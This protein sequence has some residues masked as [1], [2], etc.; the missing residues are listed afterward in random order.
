[1]SLRAVLGLA[2]LAASFARL[3]GL[4]AYGFSEDE[5]AKL[6]ALDAYRQGDFSVNA[7]HPMLMKLAMW[8]SLGAA[9]S[10]N[11][12]V[13]AVLRIPPETALRLPNALAGIAMVAATC[14]VTTTFF[15]AAAGGLAGLL[16]ALDPNVIALNRIGKED[17]FLMLFLMVAVAAYERAKRIGARDPARAQRWYYASGIGF[18]LMLASKYMPHLFGLYALYNVVVER[19]PGANR[20]HPLRYNGLILAAFIAGNFAILLPSTWEYGLAYIRGQQS[21]HHGYLYAGDLYVNSATM[22]MHGVPF[23][24]YFHLLATKLP[25]AT[26]AGAAAGL[27]LIVTRRRER[28]F[29]WLRIF[30]L[31]QLFG[32]SVMAAKFLRYALPLLIV[33]DM[34]A[35]VGLAAIATAI[36]S[37][38]WPRHVRLGLCFGGLLFAVGS[39][40]AA[41]V[42]SA[43]FYSTFQN[44][45]GASLAPPL[46]TFPEE[47]YDFGVR[48]AVAAISLVAQP[49]AAIV[50]DA[51]LVVGHYLRGRN[52]PDIE[53]RSLSSEGTGRRREQ[54]LL[55][56]DAHVYFENAS[57]I[58]QV[59][60]S[61]TPWREYTLRGTPVLQVY[62][63]RR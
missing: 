41:T 43:P 5:V 55:I 42:R 32:Y 2:L 27:P 39:S 18:G 45:I 21:S 30:L 37:R 44:A 7:E 52:R 22:L 40:T 14:A 59:R 53:V 31:V 62:Q 26:L 38:P 50:S 3:N 4:D 10:W 34:L 16:V 19:N 57:L 33:V 48:E 9:G 8:G 54:W 24:Y 20:P 47:A 63:V 25:L 13:P 36:W 12:R 56:Q 58:A 46:T 23:A 17:T 60:R 61:L 29:V 1:M 51:S 6:H 49:G 11:D 15:G 28:G 35:A